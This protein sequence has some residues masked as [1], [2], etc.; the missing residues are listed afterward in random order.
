MNM[1][2]NIS[3]L[4]LLILSAVAVF[5]TSVKEKLKQAKLFGVE[6]TTNKISEMISENKF[7]KNYDKL[8]YS[9]LQQKGKGHLSKNV[10]LGIVVFTILTIIYFFQMGQIFFG[11]LMPIAF[12][13]VIISILKEMKYDVNYE[14]EKQLPSVIDD[15]I[16]KFSRYND[17]KT[18]VYEISLDAQMP[19]KKHFEGLY[20]ELFFKDQNEALFEFAEKI[21]NIWIHSLVF[22]LTSYKEDTRKEI[23]IENL[24]NLRELLQKERDLQAQ[25]T[26]DNRYGVALNYF[27]SIATIIANIIIMFVVPTAKAF[28]FKDTTGILCFSVGYTFLFLTLLTNVKNQFKKKKRG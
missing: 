9:A 4:I 16:Q 21:D 3:L 10:L 6:N 13:Y 11:I 24:R 22:I 20:K 14:I 17:L 26:N 15:I 8:L 28:F 5:D 27:I 19:L 2:I 1:I 25:N 7:I 18:V 23:I 12:N